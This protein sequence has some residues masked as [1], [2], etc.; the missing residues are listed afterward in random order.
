MYSGLIKPRLIF[1]VLVIF[2]RN[3]VLNYKNLCTRLHPRFFRGVFSF[4]PSKWLLT[5]WLSVMGCRSQIF[6]M[7]YI[8]LVFFYFYWPTLIHTTKDKDNNITTWQKNHKNVS[9]TTTPKCS[10]QSKV[11]GLHFSLNLGL[12]I[13]NNIP[14]SVYFFFPQRWTKHKMYWCTLNLWDCDVSNPAHLICFSCRTSN[15]CSSYLVCSSQA[16]QA[17]ALCP[18]TW[19]YDWESPA[20]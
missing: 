3:Q 19:W 6:A 5:F 2:E 14:S 10:L 17:R 12:N 13:S 16:Y 9:T 1:N 20:R 18:N 8:G 11:Q 4:H 15:L 7:I